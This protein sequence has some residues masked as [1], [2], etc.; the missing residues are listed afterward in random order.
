MYMFGLTVAHY[1]GI[2]RI[3][4]VGFMVL[5]LVELLE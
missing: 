2:Y 3:G 1:G 5:I 4:R